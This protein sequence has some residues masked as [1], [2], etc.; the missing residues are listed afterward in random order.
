MLSSG[1]HLFSSS[2]F[3]F[4][5]LFANQGTI[6]DK[7]QQLCLYEPSAQ[8]MRKGLEWLDKSRVST[9][10]IRKVAKKV[11]IFSQPLESRV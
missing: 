3:N 7:E 9:E 11:F 10:K 1:I 5:Q 8:T 6:L 4:Q 2:S